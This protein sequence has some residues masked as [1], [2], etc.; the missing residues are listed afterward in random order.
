MKNSTVTFGEF[1]DPQRPQQL[2]LKVEEVGNVQTLA[3]KGCPWRFYPSQCVV[4]IRTVSDIQSVLTMLHVS[5]D[6][7]EVAQL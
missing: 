7:G 5:S 1:K 6:M 3:G 2:P 4:C